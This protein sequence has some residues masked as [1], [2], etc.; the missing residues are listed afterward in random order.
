M[1]NEKMVD[2][3]MTDVIA[4]LENER[5]IYEEDLNKCDDGEEFVDIIDRIPN[6]VD[7]VR[8][9]LP[10]GCRHTNDIIAAVNEAFDTLIFHKQEDDVVRPHYTNN[11]LARRVIDATI[12]I[13]GFHF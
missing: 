9:V 1:L 7:E 2:A 6:I 8:L 4:V 5:D 3:V 12:Y 13:F 10:P 11:Q